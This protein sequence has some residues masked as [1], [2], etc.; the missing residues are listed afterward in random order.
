V[1]LAIGGGNFGPGSLRSAEFGTLN[2]A[3]GWSS[4]N[5]FP[6][7]LADVN[8]DRLADIVGFGNAGVT[9]ALATGGGNF[10]P[11]SLRLSQFG[12]SNSAGG[13]ANDELYPRELGDVNGDGLADIVGFGIAGVTVALATGG[14]NFGPASL[15]SGEFGTS[16]SAGGYTSND[17]FPREVAD[18]SGDQRADLIGFGH[19]GVFTSQSTLDFFFV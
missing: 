6:R 11:G 15:L 1:A 2:S 17:L 19:S 12:L 9:V 3:G 13:W 14:G 16:N 8:G 18:V 10:G 4:N 5:L 7:E